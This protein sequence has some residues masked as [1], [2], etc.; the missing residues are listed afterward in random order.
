MNKLFTIL[1]FLLLFSLELFSQINLTM[2]EARRLYTVNRP[3]RV[4]VH[5]PSVVWDERS[6][7]Y[8]L[9]GSHRAQARS[10]DLYHWSAL[11]PPAPWAVTNN[12]GTLTE[13]TNE[14]AFDTPEQISVMKDG[15]IRQL[16]R[17]N[18][19][20]WARRASTDYNVNGNMWAPDIIYN[21]AMKKWCMYLSI[22]GD[23][24]ASSIILLTADRITGPYVYQA[25]VVI[26]GFNGSNPNSYK[27]TDLELVIGSMDAL[28][29]R[30]NKNKSW[31]MFWPNN[32]DP[33]VFYDE[34]G[35]LRMVYGSWSGGI[36]QL[37]LDESTGLR[38][39]DVSY[40]LRFVGNNYLSDPYFGK[41]IAGGCYVSGEGAYVKHI[42]QYYYLFLSYGGLSSTGGY[43]IRIFRS[44][45]PDGPFTDI[46]NN[47]AIYPAWVQNF[48][49]GASVRGVKLFGAYQDWGFL[50]IGNSG[51]LA[52]GHNSVIT[53]RH[54]RHF[55]VYHTRFN[56]GTERHEVR[57]HQ[58]FTTRNGWLVAAPFEF[59][60]ETVTDDTILQKS[61]F[62]DSDII[63]EY[64][65]IIHR[66]GLD[67]KNRETL[68]PSRIRLHEDGTITGDLN[69]LWSRENGTCYFNIT[70]DGSTYQSV[71]ITQHLEP[72]TIKALA[73]T[74]LNESGI[75]IWGY[76]MQDAYRLAYFANTA[77]RPV[78]EGSVIRSNIFLGDIGASAY[79]IRCDWKSS[80][81][82]ILSNTG[83]YHPEA[84]NHESEI[85][86][87]TITLTAGGY[88]LTDSIHV[89]VRKTAVAPGADYRT[90]TR[91]YYNFDHIP[92]HNLFNVNHTALLKHQSNTPLPTVESDEGRSGSMIHTAFGV[93]G[94]ASYVEMPNPLNN[95]V[96]GDGCTFAFRVKRT[97]NNLW[98]ALFAF[99]NADH[100]GRLYCTGNAYFGFNDNRNNWIDLNYPNAV[101]TNFLPIGRWAFVTLTLSRSAG[102]N[103]YVDGAHQ[104]WQTVNGMQNGQAVR[105]VSQ[106]DYGMMLD[107]LTHCP[108]MY[109]GYGSFWG[110]ADACFDDLFVFDR[111]LSAADV[112]GL[113]TALRRGD[114]MVGI[115]PITTAR[116]QTSD[117]RIYDLQGR[118]L[119]TSFRCLSKGLYVR[120]GRKFIVR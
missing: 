94:A 104:A 68:A 110:S 17:F 22:N 105:A 90:G 47:S 9:F 16:P 65:V 85:V 83:D 50:T 96:A 20:E 15:Q 78:E 49:P 117:E 45:N 116:L 28:P 14:R 113:Y 8:F 2:E 39:Y 30:Y 19:E 21:R 99:F 67:H 101:T 23:N 46:A 102:I 89:D 10:T 69:G 79:D 57:V 103:L 29:E 59:T 118:P 63:G 5:D 43:E 95:L 91:A 33:C 62:T 107:F 92:L 82:D 87:L 18:A 70:I 58:L 88:A 54:G 12:N 106:F 115:T 4:S 77:R 111:V 98:D 108:K 44:K 27:L 66:P 42:G 36:W 71:L 35:Q 48:G 32:I 55:I 53:D 120:Q 51:E 76:K 11:T 73:F 112:A 97:D 24:W 40:P 1:P 93:A 80:H 72:Y 34:Q 3:A 75:T 114:D 81:P 84:M 56:D 100:G 52:Q 61:L 74:G 86:T 31:G 119:G 41:K 7:H 26:S 6:G 13:V 109:L 25:P 64:R 38:D 60:G 37:E